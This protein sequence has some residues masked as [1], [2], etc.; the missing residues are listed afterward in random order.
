MFWTFQIQNLTHIVNLPVLKEKLG[1]EDKLTVY[2]LIFP[3]K[4]V[5]DLIIFNWIL[6]FFLL[7]NIWTLYYRNILQNLFEMNFPK[8]IM[9]ILAA[10][11]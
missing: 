11:N 6:G 4:S 8:F 7:F 5:S 1:L 2:T 3:N 9:T 10:Q